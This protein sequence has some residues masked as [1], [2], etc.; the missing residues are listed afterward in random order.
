MLTFRSVL[1]LFL[2]VA[3]PG[4]ALT[5]SGQARVVDGDSLVVDAQKLRLFGI[6]AP[7]L[8]QRCNLSGRDWACGAWA[9]EV[10]G[11]IIAQGKPVCEAL[12]RD[13]YGR[14]VARC[15]V[16]G[17]DVAALMVQA[18]AA[19][20]YVKY[21]GDYVGLEAVAKA[22]SQGVWAG[23]MMR[24]AD[25]RRAGQRQDP[26]QGC[27]IKGNINAKGKRI[28]HMPGQRDWT[29]T[30]ISPAKGESFFCSEAQAQA[31]GFRAAK[32]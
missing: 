28:Y 9:A 19:V 12:D 31:A 29:K 2:A 6:D 17:R 18:G 5:V 10:L 22:K 21:S 15:T 13:R 3:T 23:E 20:A 1:V 27:Q 14:T 7:E 11:G 26:P 25:Y 4:A 16:A 32:R 24:P 8:G 30:R